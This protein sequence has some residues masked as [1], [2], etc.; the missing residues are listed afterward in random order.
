MSLIQIPGWGAVDIRHLVL[1]YNGTIAL[2]GTMLPTVRQQLQEIH[3]QG[4]AIHVITADTNGTARAACQGMD[5]QLHI[6]QGDA[7]ALEKQK[8]VQEL[9]PEHTVCMGNGRNDLGMFQTGALSVCII[10]GEGA[11]VPTLLAA[12]LAVTNITDGL[13]LL[14]RPHRLCASLRG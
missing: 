2:D 5:I 6:H 1:D 4:I 10:G 11:Y 8:L 14:I 7:V 12:Q 9:G 13:D 3:Q